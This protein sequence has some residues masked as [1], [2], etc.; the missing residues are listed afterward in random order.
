MAT[1]EPLAAPAIGS[2]VAPVA[3]T[4]EPTKASLTREHAS[5]IDKMRDHFAA[6]PKRRIRVREEQFVQVNGY[7]FRIMPGEFVMVPEQV[8]EI[9]E[10]S[11]RI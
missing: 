9:L 11:D 4:P 7:S 5:Q 6:Q 8:A 3:I 10:E 2:A 1:A